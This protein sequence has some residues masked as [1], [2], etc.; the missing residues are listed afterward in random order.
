MTDK[1]PYRCHLF[2]CVND[3][4]GE[5]KSCADGG[6]VQIRQA[7][8][9]RINQLQLPTG[10]IRVSQ[11]GCF[12]LCCEGPNVLIYPQAIWYSGV[13]MDDIET[14]IAKIKELLTQAP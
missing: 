12:G 1:A 9:E 11:S 10:S 4:H 2:V 14:I 7:L 8:K 3:R 5:R 13:G 6:G